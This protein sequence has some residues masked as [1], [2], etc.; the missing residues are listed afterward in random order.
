MLHMPA[1][2]GASCHGSGP[3]KAKQ[4]VLQ[5]RNKRQGTPFCRGLPL[6]RPAAP[7]HPCTLYRGATPERQ[8]AEVFLPPICPA[9]SPR[10]LGR[11]GRVRS[12]TETE[13]GLDDAVPREVE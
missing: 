12:R 9:R 4:P 8:A 5:S 3:Q 13:M 6:H 10:G 7:Q 2:R 11:K 1:Q